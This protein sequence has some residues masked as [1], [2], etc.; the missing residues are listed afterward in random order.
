MPLHTW[1]LLN[2][3]LAGE[4]VQD[5]IAVQIWCSPPPWENWKPHWDACMYSSWPACRPKFYK[6][7]IDVLK[8]RWSMNPWIARGNW[9]VKPKCILEGCS[10]HHFKG[11]KLSSPADHKWKCALIQLLQLFRGNTSNHLNWRLVALRWDQDSNSWC[12][13]HAY[14]LWQCWHHS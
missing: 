10:K 4:I 2:H 12:W 6:L 14:P 9:K 5:C 3:R 11:V 13:V 1:L 8:L 7:H